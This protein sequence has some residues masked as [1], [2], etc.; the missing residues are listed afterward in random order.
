MVRGGDFSMIKVWAGLEARNFIN[1]SVEEV[2]SAVHHGASA[3][4][5][6][7]TSSFQVEKC[8]KYDRLSPNM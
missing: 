4:G 7:L 2:S 1:V 5:L 6:A 3:R 8:V